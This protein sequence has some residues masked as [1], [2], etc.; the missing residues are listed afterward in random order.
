MQYAPDLIVIEAEGILR[1]VMERTWD[2]LDE[3]G[4]G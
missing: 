1:L 4:I 3:P 2:L